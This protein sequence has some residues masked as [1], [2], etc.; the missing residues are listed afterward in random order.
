MTGPLCDA[1]PQPG[2]PG[3]PDVLASE[4]PD[5]ALTWIPVVTTFEAAVRATGLDTELRDARG[6]TILAPTDDAFAAAFSESTID[7]LLIFRHDE[8]RGL[9]ES[10]IIDG[11]STVAQ[12][13]E[14]GTVTTRAG[15]EVTVDPAGDGMALLGGNARTVCADY[16]AAGARIHVIDGVLG[17]HPPPAATE[18]PHVG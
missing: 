16:Q 14:V 13:L 9:L 18:E 4:P 15:D 6:V 8:L 7:D 17:E 5:V 12:L 2:E 11:A 1:L 10:H 3:G